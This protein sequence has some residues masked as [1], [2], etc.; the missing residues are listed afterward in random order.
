MKAERGKTKETILREALKLFAREG[1][2]GTSMAALARRVC[3]RKAS[4][5]AHY[6]GKKEIFRAVFQGVLTDYASHLEKSEIFTE[7]KGPLQ[8]RLCTLLLGYASYFSDAMQWGSGTGS[9]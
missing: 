8:E 1:Y 4:L 7:G 6:R 5:Y 2:E 3:V 9:P